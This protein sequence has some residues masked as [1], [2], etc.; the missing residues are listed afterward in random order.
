MGIQS[1]PAPSTA[2]APFVGAGSV[3]VSTYSTQGFYTTTL[4]AGKY[5]ITVDAAGG[6]TRRTS[7]SDDNDGDIQNAPKWHYGDSI[8]DQ[9]SSNN[10]SGTSI[11]V[12]LTTASQIWLHTDQRFDRS[13]NGQKYYSSV[14]NSQFYRTAG[15]TSAVSDIDVGIPYM[16]YF[17]NANSSARMGWLLAATTFSGMGGGFFDQSSRI[18]TNSV[19]SAGTKGIVLNSDRMFVLQGSQLWSSTNSTS[20][21]NI[22]H[23]MSET[24]HGVAKGTV[25][26]TYVAVSTSGTA[27]ANLS[28]TTDGITW[29]TRNSGVSS[30]LN[31][32][33][34]GTIYVAAGDSGV[35]TTSTDGY[36]WTSRTSPTTSTNWG[37]ALYNN[38]I[39]LLIGNNTAN[40]INAAYSTNGTTWTAKAITASAKADLF[41]GLRLNTALPTAYIAENDSNRGGNFFA[42]G[43]YFWLIQ[44]GHAR[45]ST[46]AVTW[47]QFPMSEKFFNS[48]N[49]WGWSTANNGLV[50]HNFVNDH[51][52]AK[53]FP[54]PAQYTIYNYSS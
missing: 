7:S 34:F 52:V 48:Y 49:H 33:I 45:V 41:T 5:L 11:V 25:A 37:M 31:C 50:G 6:Y 44:Y 35:I 20:W 17:N 12:N 39:Y 19:E 32:V 1:I 51:P 2:S 22:T 30:G 8:N 27:T 10:L 26:N 38:G 14:P 18:A 46:D 47:Q 43:G 3:A 54:T 15:F 42:G 28:V 9:Y 24:V 13:P 23:G 53:H 16:G 29:G 4:A 40:V 36:T 21:T